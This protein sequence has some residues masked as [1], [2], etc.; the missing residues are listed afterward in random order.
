MTI[1]MKVAALAAAALALAP[2]AAA[3]L[4]DAKWLLAQPEATT[5]LQ[6]ISTTRNYVWA[7]DTVLGALGSPVSAPAPVPAPTPAPTP[8]PVPVPTPSP[9][10]APVPAPVPPPSAGVAISG[11]TALLNALSGA[12][13]GETFTLADGS[14]TLAITNKRF[15]TPVT[16]QGGRGARFGA[17]G[18]ITG[19]SGVTIKGVTFLGHAGMADAQWSIQIAA[20]DTIT[21]DTVL[22][23]GT[24]G[25]GYGLY[26]RTGDVK[27]ITLRNSEI[28]KFKYG[29]VIAGG[30]GWLI[31]GNSFHTITSDG[32]QISNSSG[33]KI[34]RNRFFN[35][36]PCCGFHPDGTQM[37]GPNV[38]MTISFN[39]YR[40]KMQG[41]FYDG[42]L[43][44]QTNLTAV[45]NDIRVTYPNAFRV[46]NATGFVSGN[47]VD[48]SDATYDGR[49]V[50]PI[51][52][53]SGMTS[54]RTNRVD[55][56]AF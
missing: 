36:T 51:V 49:K 53:F 34:L 45:G 32:I 7:R 1:G 41:P 48:G 4:D 35:F 23:G 28:A 18:K 30:T 43:G 39:H 44:P 21:F 14:Y 40:G 25:T 16:L 13:G 50:V 27:A 19:S 42:R 22:I 9:G 54:D 29:V 33:A 24:D 52:Q 20:S 26:V 47:V 31:E 5:A 56:K 46:P 2:V 15:T 10:P 17:Y 37:S 55:G 11:Q 38:N 8:T 6:G 3:P 12:K